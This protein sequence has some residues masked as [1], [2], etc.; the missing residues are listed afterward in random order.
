[1]KKYRIV[2]LCLLYSSCSDLAYACKVQI[3]FKFS[4]RSIQN[5][6]EVASK[7]GIHEGYFIS[8]IENKKGAEGRI[9]LRNGHGNCKTLI[10]S[11]SQPMCQVEYKFIKET[12]CS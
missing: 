4:Q 5:L 8:K 3:N 12:P 1:M 9:E 6:L 7:T 2:F 11:A 10:F